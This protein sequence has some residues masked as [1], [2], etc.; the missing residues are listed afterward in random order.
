V[1]PAGKLQA[2]AARIRA[3]GNSVTGKA[4]S[5][6]RGTGIT[7]GVLEERHQPVIK[8]SKIKRDAITNSPGSERFVITRFTLL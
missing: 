1:S 3:A 4:A 6:G 7:P 2:R 8:L 5:T